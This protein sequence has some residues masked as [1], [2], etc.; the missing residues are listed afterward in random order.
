MTQALFIIDGCRQEEPHMEHSK[1]TKGWVSM[2]L[3]LNSDFDDVVNNQWFKDWLETLD[4]ESFDRSADIRHEESCEL[5][6][7]TLV[8]SQRTNGLFS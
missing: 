8:S 3:N 5:L 1:H 6:S 7:L 2:D 4:F